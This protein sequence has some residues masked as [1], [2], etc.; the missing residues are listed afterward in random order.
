MAATV[1]TQPLNL[2]KLSASQT[3]I[4]LEWDEPSSTGSTP[5]IDYEVFW[6]NAAENGVF[7]LLTATTGNFLTYTVSTGLVAGS[8]YS[9]KVRSRNN[10]GTSAFSNTVVVVAALLPG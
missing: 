3:S 5:I 8:A 10:I 6:D 7:V 1:S 4:S 2:R 9:F